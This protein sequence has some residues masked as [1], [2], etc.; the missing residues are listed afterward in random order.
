M[1]KEDISTHFIIFFSVFK[2][3]NGCD[4]NNCFDLDKDDHHDHEMYKRIN[5]HYMAVW[6]ALQI[7]TFE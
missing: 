4:D 1:I 5:T 2:S 3:D 6:C 7:R